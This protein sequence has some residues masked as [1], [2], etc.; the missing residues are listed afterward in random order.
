MDM[1]RLKEKIYLVKNLVNSLDFDSAQLVHLKIP[2]GVLRVLEMQDQTP[3]TETEM[4]LE[5]WRGL[6]GGRG[7]YMVE[8]E[9]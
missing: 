6:G 8:L 4:I 1:G 2:M 5:S 9:D 3:R 7:K